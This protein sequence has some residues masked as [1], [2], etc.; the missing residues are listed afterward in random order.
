MDA[1]TRE[2]TLRE[3]INNCRKLP[4]EVECR[5]IIYMIEDMISGTLEIDEPKIHYDIPTSVQKL[6]PSNQHYQTH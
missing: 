6:L 2:E 1:K 5:D 3:V 4:P